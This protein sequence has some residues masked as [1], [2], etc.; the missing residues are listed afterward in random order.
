MYVHVCVHA[1]L[2]ALHVHVQ[3][4][5]CVYKIK[6]RMS[7]ILFCHSQ[8]YVFETWSLTESGAMLGASEPSGSVF[9][10]YSP[11]VAVMF[12]DTLA[13]LMGIGI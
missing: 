7:G 4:N 6:R 12:T 5:T 11:G 3:M 8:L 10:P 2:C 13:S 9:T 1:H